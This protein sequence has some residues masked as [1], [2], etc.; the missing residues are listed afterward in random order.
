[1]KCHFEFNHYFE[2]SKMSLTE[3]YN[4]TKPKRYKIKELGSFDIIKSMD[5]ITDFK[6][7]VTE[8]LINK[9]K[10]ANIPPIKIGKLDNKII[11]TIEQELGINIE[12][13]DIYITKDKISHIR[14]ERKG[15][16]NQA[17]S[18]DEIKSIPNVLSDKKSLKTLD[19]KKK[20]LIFW[21][22]DNI[23][24]EKMNKIIL[25]FNY[26]IKKMKDKSNIVVTVGK[27]KKGDMNAKWYKKI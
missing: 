9:N 11:K 13:K 6:T 4:I 14:T 10:K 22:E 3:F 1:M 17:F 27:V 15:E 2:N 21:F 20:N 5:Q 26:K 7:A 8:L 16:Y 19:L 24:N 23:D 18:F 12:S 25:E